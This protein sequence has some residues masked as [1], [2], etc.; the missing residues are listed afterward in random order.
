MLKL[1]LTNQTEIITSLEKI[2]LIESGHCDEHFIN[3]MIIF[4]HSPNIVYY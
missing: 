4:S 2:T 1:I 3:K